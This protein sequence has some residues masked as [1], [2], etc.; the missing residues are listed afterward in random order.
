MA[1]PTVQ[2][3]LNS[4]SRDD[5][6]NLGVGIEQAED[7]IRH[8][9]TNGGIRSWEELGQIPGFSPESVEEI[10]LCGATLGE[11][12]KGTPGVDLA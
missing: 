9:E 8:R 5:L 10:R 1:E 2:I 7:L 4:A 11:L 6:T 12:S 3:D